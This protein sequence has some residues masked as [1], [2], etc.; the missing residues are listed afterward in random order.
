[1]RVILHLPVLLAL[2]IAGASV[3]A[4]RADIG[5]AEPVTGQTT[6][7]V[8]AQAGALETRQAG[9]TVTRRVP[10]A[11]D[12]QSAGPAARQAAESG[13][14][15]PAVRQA[16]SLDA[17]ASAIGIGALGP[18]QRE[19]VKRALVERGLE[20]D[21]QPE[22]K[23]VGRIIVKNFDIF[24]DSDGGFISWTNMF[25]MTTRENIIARE[26]L[27]QPGDS[28]DWTI[29]EETRRRLADPLFTS[30]AAVVPVRALA[31][32]E[33]NVLVVT[34]DIFSLRLN[35]VFEFQAGTFSWLHIEPAENNLLGRRKRLSAIFEMD[36]G[37]YGVGPTYY[38]SNI[39]GSRW[40]ANM[41][42]RALI[43]RDSES[44]EGSEGNVTIRHP[45]WAYSRHWGA[46]LSVTHF[47]G[48]NRQFLGTNLRPYDDPATLATEQVPWSYRYRSF[49]GRA[50]V[51]HQT[52]RRV[53][54]A[55][56]AG[57]RFD[58]RRPEVFEQAFVG[59]PEL[60]LAFERDVLPRS[61]RVSAPLVSYQVFTPRF[62]TFHDLSTFDLPEDQ[63]LG[64]ELIMSASWASRSLGSESGF[65]LLS[66]T[67]RFNAEVGNRGLLML[68]SG[69]EA[70]I[71]EQDVV[72]RR[73][74]G[75][76]WFGSPKVLA[77]VRL[78][79]NLKVDGLIKNKAV[80]NLA[81]GGDNGLRGYAIGAFQGQALVRGNVELRSVGLK[82]A[83]TR[84]GVAG[85]WD[86]GHA[87]PSFS[88]LVIHHD[89]GVGL[90]LLIPQLQPTV[91]RCDWAF[92]TQGPTAGFPGRITAGFSQGF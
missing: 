32:G 33:V 65:T 29:A 64:P 83:F 44:V 14:A 18:Y 73:Y 56:S 19:A 72:D 5:L 87:A 43:G 35:T 78:I 3:R 50:Q 30:F 86:F 23:R 52:G 47:Q 69:A 20:L 67:A 49:H 92:A 26:V 89:V 63:K 80:R 28:W 68:S 62:V 59:A 24:D 4:A 81:L 6:A 45:L 79:A 9:T 54:Q 27:L 34:R 46:E 41:F 7:P 8:A 53:I 75:E 36:L 22:G 40:T 25:H 90:R 91:M 71:T 76:A 15:V 17:P 38:D 39:V 12:A 82:I 77:L 85:F 16:G 11:A 10:G 74:V 42:A 57:Y 55:F 61:E 21:L 48:I 2:L 13:A 1:M 84:L 70:R 66:A 31:P 88:D 58:L 51:T 37:R 60:R